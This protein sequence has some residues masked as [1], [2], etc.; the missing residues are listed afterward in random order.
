[1]RQRLKLDFARANT[2]DVQDGKLSGLLVQRPW[3]TVVDG[4]ERSVVD[5]VVPPVEVPPDEVDPEVPAVS[6]GGMHALVA[7]TIAPASN[8]RFH[9][10]PA[11]PMFI[12]ASAASH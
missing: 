5:V 6:S 11:T 2:L 3:G 8:E 12:F 10:E 1:M 4:A 9:M 7:S